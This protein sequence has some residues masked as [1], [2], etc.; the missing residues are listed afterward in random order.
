MSMILSTR[1][2]DAAVTAFRTGHGDMHRWSATDF[3]R[4]EQLLLIAR[5][6]HNTLH[7]TVVRRV[8]VVSVIG[9]AIALYALTALVS[10]VKGGEWWPPKRHT[11]WV[12]AQITAAEALCVRT[13]DMAFGQKVGTAIE[14]LV[15]AVDRRLPMRR[16]TS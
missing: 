2:A 12:D 14:Y 6:A 13:G 3:D 15:G 11:D 9:Y 4:Y 16:A 7:S 1:K 5:A 8:R 10:I